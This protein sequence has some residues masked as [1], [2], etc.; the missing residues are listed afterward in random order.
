MEHEVKML[1][2][3]DEARR[4]YLDGQ[5]SKHNNCTMWDQVI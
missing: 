5:L 2:D 4:L 3:Q 1:V